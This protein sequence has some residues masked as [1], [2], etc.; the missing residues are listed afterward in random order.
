MMD[1]VLLPGNG[2]REIKMLPFIKRLRREGFNPIYIELL[3]N[4]NDNLD[5]DILQPKEYSKYIKSR[6][7]KNKQYIFY[8]I[9]MGCLHAQNFA[10]FYPQMVKCLV[11]IEP[12]ISSGY[13]PAL[14]DFEAGR[15]NGRW[16]KML[17]DVKEDISHLPSNEK[18]IDI[19]VSKDKPL[20]FDRDI[21]I[22]IVYTNLDNRG[23][24]YNQQQWIGK[25]KYLQ[26]LEEKGYC[27]YF[28]MKKGH[29][30]L[31]LFKEN[32]DFLV[33]VIESTLHHS[34]SD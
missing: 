26:Y 28:V 14:Y 9:S 1:I 15:G 27:V 16:L 33:S 32:F 2:Y 19:A 21:V 7:N 8:G 4:L 29:H 18:V 10:H 13:F 30:C 25:M 24:P 20:E 5:Y 31:D 34:M 23:M 11:L 6:L 22:G 3:E 12:T 17:Y